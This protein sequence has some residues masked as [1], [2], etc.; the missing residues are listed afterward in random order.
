MNVI[1]T[2]T[3]IFE[4]M[5]LALVRGGRP[6]SG[7]GNGRSGSSQE[8]TRWSACEPTPTK[9]ERSSLAHDGAHRTGGL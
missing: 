2:I 6:A 9:R 3:M 8:Y 4:V 7:V 1:H 5:P